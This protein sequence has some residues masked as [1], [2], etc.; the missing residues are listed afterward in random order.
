MNDPCRALEE[1]LHREIP[2][3]GHMQ[4]RVERFDGNDLIVAAELEPNINIHGTAFGGSLYSI[5]AL[6]CWSRL[7][8]LLAERNSNAQ[9]V[10]GKA[11]IQ[12]LKPVRSQ[13]RARC[14][15]PEGDVL[16]SFLQQLSD[17]D[18][19]AIDLRA[20][21]LDG[22]AVAVCFTGYYSSF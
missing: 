12:Y 8:L 21:V 1:M 14:R 18:R 2:L 16:R 7:H 22:D 10:L 17:G 3:A 5:C 6:T 20:E 15:L 11:A 19:A 13:I 9:I 4:V